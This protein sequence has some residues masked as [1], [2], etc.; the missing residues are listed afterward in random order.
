[1][2]LLTP[3]LE[4]EINLLHERICSA[5]GDP[6]RVLLLYALAEGPQY[7]GELVDHL[8]IPQSTVSR[9]LRVL[10][11][12]GLIHA[13]RKGTAMYYTITDYRIIQALDILRGILT[14]QL[15]AGAELAQSLGD[16]V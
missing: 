2:S 12:R 16:E 3:R 13:E 4:Q 6:K 14:A 11:E 9:H 1:M 15:T 7:V 8:S 10:R 5:L